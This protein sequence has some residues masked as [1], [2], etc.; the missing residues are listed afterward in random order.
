MDGMRITLPL[1]FAGMAASSQMAANAVAYWRTPCPLTLVHISATA[2]N[3]ASS[4][5]RVGTSSDDDGYITAFAVGQSATPVV[6]DRGDFDGALNA[7]ANECPH[8]ARDTVLAVTVDYDGSSGTA[9]QN[10]SVILTFV[11]G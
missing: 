4:T 10:V 1:T 5:V 9:G 8:I 3:A 6:K 2:S 7:D 11:E